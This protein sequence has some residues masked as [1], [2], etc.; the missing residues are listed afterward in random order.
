MFLFR[1]IAYIGAAS[2]LIAV[3]PWSDTIDFCARLIGATALMWGGF[4]FM[5]RENE[6][7]YGSVCVILSVLTQP[8]YPIP[9]GMGT[10]MVVSLICAG[11]LILC[12]LLSKKLDRIHAEKIAQR[13]ADIEMY[14]V[15]EEQNRDNNER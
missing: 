5:I 2:L 4:Y 15:M 8:I 10:W 1:F 7:L 3:I 11:Y 13:K 6:M 9:Y 14:R 12:G